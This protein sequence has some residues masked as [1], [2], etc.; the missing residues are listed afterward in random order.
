M[1]NPPTAP[2]SA[3]FE[4]EPEEEGR[5]PARAVGRRAEE[6]AC[7]QRAATKCEAV[8]TLEWQG[9]DRDET[10]G[11]LRRWR[12]SPDLVPLRLGKPDRRLVRRS[13]PTACACRRRFGW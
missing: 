1:S 6:A 11:R 5:L 10:P 2:S 4:R 7:R 8:M 12:S 9:S 13:C 3:V